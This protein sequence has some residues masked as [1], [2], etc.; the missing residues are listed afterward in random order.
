[1]IQVCSQNLPSRYWRSLQNLLGSLINSIEAIGM[2][3]KIRNAKLLGKKIP[4]KPKS[5][6][7][8]YK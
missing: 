4:P 6:C 3:N 5:K 1:M 2:Y 7:A 8:K